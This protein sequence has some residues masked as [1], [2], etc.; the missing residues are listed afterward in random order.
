MSRR[1]ILSLVT[2]FLLA[3]VLYF[4]RHE[5]YIAW[6][7]IS[8]VNIWIL[9]L[10]I[11]AQFFVYFAAGEMMFE[12]LRDKKALRNVSRLTLTRMALELNFVNHILPS[13]GVSGISYMTWRLGKYGVSPGR[14]TI[15]QV[16][17]Y[18]AGFLSFLTLLIISVVLITLDS[19][20]D[21]FIILVS[22]VLASTIV[23]F[24]VFGIYILSSSVRLRGF[25]HWSTHAINNS[26]R[27]VTFGR[28]KHT[29]E[30]ENVEK[31]F[32]D[33]HDDFVE[34]RAD[35]RLLLKPYL[36]GLLYNAMDVG[37]FMIGFWALGYSVNPAAITI[38][39]GIASIAG[40]IVITPGGAGAY[41]ALMIAFLGTAGLP[42][43]VVIAGVL[44]TR[45]ILLLGTVVSGYV[46]YQLTILKY[47]KTPVKSE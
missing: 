34:L 38:A 46:F 22:S 31:F 44:L 42:A 28:K 36:W 20:V 43:G 33:F 15:A 39:Y 13:G 32:S 8:Q 3:L 4:A 10:L 2:L 47:G 25:A 30:L 26:V 1:G 14:A 41:E 6:K 27:R 23:C 9:A 29:L 35:K 45:V 19:G 37:L 21:R 7:L 5:I 11:P 12:Y 16:V 40:F 24:L 17:R 18:A